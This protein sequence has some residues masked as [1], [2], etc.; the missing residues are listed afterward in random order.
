MIITFLFY[1]YDKHITTPKTQCKKL[2][3]QVNDRVSQNGVA[4]VS[5]KVKRMTTLEDGSVVFKAP[6]NSFAEWDF[7]RLLNYY[8]DDNGKKREV[9]SLSPVE[10]LALCRMVIGGEIHEVSHANDKVFSCRLR[11]HTIVMPC[12][13]AQVVHTLTTSLPRKDI[14]DWV[15]VIFQ[16]TRNSYATKIAGQLNHGR[17]R[18]EYEK[19]EG[20]IKRLRQTG[21]YDGLELLSESECQWKDNV[22]AV[23]HEVAIF[24]DRRAALH[25]AKVRSDVSEQWDPSCTVKQ[26]KVRVVCWLVCLCVKRCIRVFTDWFV[27]FV[28]CVGCSNYC[29][30]RGGDVNNVSYR[31]VKPRYKLSHFIY[32]NG[33]RSIGSIGKTVTGRGTYHDNNGSNCGG[34]LH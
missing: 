21:V 26:D 7:G 15:K 2:T 1:I 22:D 28:V 24:N 34:S 23:Q 9:P 4:R 10:R 19:V 31:S 8:V 32:C 14:A 29:R 3:A 17:V 6:L 25:E 13:A 5:S 33:G 11:G 30:F 18:M 27:L 16:G 20:H 12:N